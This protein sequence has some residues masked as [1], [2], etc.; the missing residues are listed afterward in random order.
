MLCRRAVPVVA[1]VLLSLTLVGCGDKNMVAT[2]GDRAGGDEPL[3]PRAL[4]AVVSEYTG[5]PVEASDGWSRYE[6]D[7]NLAATVDM[8]FPRKPAWGLEGRL[9][10]WVGKDMED[11]PDTCADVETLYENSDGCEEIQDGVLFWED[12]EPE[13]DPGLVYLAMSMAGTDVLF[14]QSGP[15]IDAD[16]RAVDLVVSVPTMMQIADDPR[17]DVTTSKAAV[18]AGDQLVFWD[19]TQEPPGPTVTSGTGG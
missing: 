16:P 13:E 10:V 17:V 12:E 3:T 4:A 18:E 9:T 11:Y 6:T 14:F 1:A 5:D 7:P 8:T 15:S 19:W 2:Q